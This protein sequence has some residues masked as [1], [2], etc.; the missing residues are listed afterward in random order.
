ML[1][2]CGQRSSCIPRTQCRNMGNMPEV[3]GVG[4]QRKMGRLDRTGLPEIPKTPRSA[5]SRD[6]DGE[7]T[8]RGVE[9]TVRCSHGQGCIAQHRPTLRNLFPLDEIS[10]DG[11]MEPS[12]VVRP[13]SPVDAGDQQ[14]D[15]FGGANR[16]QKE[17]N[18]L[19]KRRIL[20]TVVGG[21]VIV[22]VTIVTGNR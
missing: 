18:M 10:K 20:R 6:D 8:V 7:S 21:A 5:T 14:E 4:G 19:R 11:R 2:L 22:I 9:P 13:M 17:G 16:I 1:E 3:C 12:D 15:S